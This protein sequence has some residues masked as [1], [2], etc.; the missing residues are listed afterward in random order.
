VLN[1]PANLRPG[2]SVVSFSPDSKR[3]I[4]GGF[5]EDTGNNVLYVVTIG[6]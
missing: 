1:F 3:M 2:G 5:S 4:A 6:Q